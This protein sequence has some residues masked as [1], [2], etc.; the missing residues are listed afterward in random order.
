MW[1]KKL[2]VWLSYLYTSLIQ[3]RLSRIINILFVTSVLGLRLIEF[4]ILE[5]IYSLSQFAM[6]V[7]SGVLGDKFGKKTIVIMGII[8]SCVSQISIC[9]CINVARNKIFPMLVFIFILEGVARAMLSGADD[10]LIFESLRSDGLAN[11]YDK[12]RGRCQF[13]GSIILGLATAV[14][15]ILYT[16]DIRTPYICQAIVTGLAIIPILKCY[17][18]KNNNLSRKKTV[19][20]M[21][22]EI[23]SIKKESV[24]IFMVFFTCL[25]TSTINTIFG[26]MP[27]YTEKIGFSSAQNGV[28]FMILSFIGGAVSSQAYRLRK[29]AYIELTLVVIFLL[30]A[31]S[32]IIRFTNSRLLVFTGLILLY[33]VIDVIDPIAMKVFQ[34][35]VSDNIRATFLSLVSFII[36]AG[37]M[38]LYPILAFFVELKGMDRIIVYVAFILSVVILFVCFLIFRKRKNEYSIS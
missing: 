38:I 24:L 20:E 7:P 27:T 18:D 8:A 3:F 37:S 2:S 4:A 5:T 31:G 11:D 23:S 22:N 16:L 34:V 6:E 19:K 33:I 12:I 14:G 21:F 36:S 10:A 32:L 35:G 13:I 17:E 26:I 9:L 28:L 30:T 1:Y 15:G 29:K 25:A